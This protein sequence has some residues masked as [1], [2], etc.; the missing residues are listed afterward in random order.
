MKEFIMMSIMDEF[1]FAINEKYKQINTSFTNKELSE[2]L[3]RESIFSHHENYTSAHIHTIHQ[4]LEILSNEPF[5]KH[6]I[7]QLEYCKSLTLFNSITESLNTNARV[8]GDNFIASCN[9]YY[10]SIGS[11]KN[12]ISSYYQGDMNF[13]CIPLKIRLAIEI[14]FKNMIGYISSVQEILTGKKKG[15]I[16]DYP[17]SISKL[18]SF[19]QKEENNKYL[20]SFPVEL[21]I[22]QDINFWANNLVHTGI[23]SYAWQN[24]AA[25]EFIK[26]LFK[27]RIDNITFHMEGFN[28]L[29]PNYKQEDLISD[30][31]S[32][33]STKFRRVTVS[34]EIFKDKPLEGA[35]YSP[36]K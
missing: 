20:D 1:K 15:E 35:F 25:I 28:Y 13:S 3:F 9:F 7:L 26:P 18:I 8:Y 22:L 23:I 5:L 14:Y 29:S 34:C 4:Q 17:L 16:C 12:Y 30:L 24:I 2:L 11:Y 19:F 31:N 10:D 21:S 32:F 6:D 27:T 33:L 36:R